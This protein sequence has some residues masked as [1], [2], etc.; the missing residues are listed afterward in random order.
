MFVDKK[1]V[2]L[3]QRYTT[4]LSFCMRS[5]VAKAH[6]SGS[7]QTQACR[8]ALGC[9]HTPS[10]MEAEKT[11][12]NMLV[13]PDTKR[14]QLVFTTHTIIKKDNDAT[15]VMLCLWRPAYN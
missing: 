11:T 5:T 6:K 3:V 13:S 12:R 14:S 1:E 4:P 9:T 7:G 2:T 8:H 10:I 15:G